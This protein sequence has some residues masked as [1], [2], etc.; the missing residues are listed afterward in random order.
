MKVTA[1]IGT[2][3][4]A[5][6]LAAC[7]SSST[8]AASP[9]PSPTAT[10]SPTPTP[11]PTPP[12]PLVVTLAG[13][14][15]LR[16][17]SLVGENGTVAATVTVPG[18]IDG[19]AYYV[20]SD[21]V[22]VIDGT[23]VKA[24]ARDGSISVAGQIPQLAT[25]VTAADR[26]AYTT[27]A[28]S[29]DESTLVF[30]IPLAVAGD[31]GATADH[32]QLWIEPTGGTAASA[33]MVYDDANN[34]DNGGEPLTPFGWNST[35]ISVSQQPKGLGGVAPFGSFAEF[36]AVTFDPTTRTL[37]KSLQCTASN[38]SGSV[39]VTQASPASPV[40]SKL[41]VVQSS[42]T[43]TLAMQPA[44]AAEY[45]AVT[46][47]ADG[48][49]LAYGS[50]IGNFAGGYYE[51]H[52][53]D[54]STNTTVATL[55]NYAPAVWLSDGRLVVGQGKYQAGAWLLSPTFTSPVKIAPDPPVGALA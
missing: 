17:L 30:G 18:G 46:V 24:L 5:I 22:Y 54:L 34:V 37:G 4:V 29:P 9:T 41:Q 13:T 55:R 50:Y 7:G 10:P 33:T 47:S 12:P 32:S 14:Q 28:V 20:G 26:Q 36:G 3:I 27:F 2:A 1:V 51:T 35:G 48:R 6:G 38:P 40:P 25:T 53:V 8:P 44:N 42:S 39:C 11:T 21:H 16:Q 23:V 52:V 49:Y 45:G 31:N 43:T 15:S 19:S